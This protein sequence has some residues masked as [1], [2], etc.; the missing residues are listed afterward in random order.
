MWPTRRKECWG[1]SAF[2]I[3]AHGMGLFM[4]CV[5]AN[6]GICATLIS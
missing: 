4:V 5:F 2:G 6:I 3:K 1:Q